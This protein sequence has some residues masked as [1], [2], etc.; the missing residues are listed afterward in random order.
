[1]GKG[2]QKTR[3]GKIFRHSFGKDRPRKVRTPAVTA[4]KA[5][6]A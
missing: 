6:K 3:K 4:K 1:M 5:K 2:D